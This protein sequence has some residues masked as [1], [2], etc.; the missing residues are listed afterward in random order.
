[1]PFSETPFVFE[2]LF[3][4]RINSRR[5]TLGNF[6]KLCRVACVCMPLSFSLGDENEDDCR[7]AIV[8][9]A[10]RNYASLYAHLV[11]IFFS[12]GFP[13]SH[14]TRWIQNLVFCFEPRHFPSISVS[15]QNNLTKKNV[16][17]L[18]I[19]HGWKHDD[20]KFCKYEWRPRDGERTPFHQICN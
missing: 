18:R 13:Y 6:A 10:V 2:K 7:S 15:M 4:C 12:F 19:E 20:K 8:K 16:F 14:S 9:L 17:S 5:V 1:M 3:S 11:S